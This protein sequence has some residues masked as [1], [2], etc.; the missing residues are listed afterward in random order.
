MIPN[1]HK[2]TTEFHSESKLVPKIE[3]RVP[4]SP[5]MELGTIELTVTSHPYVT[6]VLTSVEVKPNK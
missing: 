4:A 3:T 1:L 2:G 6:V 5:F